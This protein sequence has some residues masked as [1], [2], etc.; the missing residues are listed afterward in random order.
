MLAAAGAQLLLLLLMLWFFERTRQRLELEMRFDNDTQEY[1]AILRWPDGREQIERCRDRH[2]F[3]ATLEA[4][5]QHLSAE[6][7]TS[8]HGS[9]MLLLDGWPD[10]P[11]LR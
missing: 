2:T 10:K 11:P 9:P 6:Q 5:E 4:I 1:V 3:R 8:V 7:W